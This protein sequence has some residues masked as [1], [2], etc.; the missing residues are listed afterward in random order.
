MRRTPALPFALNFIEGVNM[1]PCKRIMIIVLALLLL[2]VSGAVAQVTNNINVTATGGAS[3]I[4]VAI[5][6][7]I[8]GD[9]P[10]SWVG[11]VVERKTIGLC[12][13]EVRLGSVSPFEAGENTYQINDSNVLQDVTYYYRVYA[14]DDQGSRQYLGSPPLFPPG[15][16]H[17]DYASLGGSGMVAQGV[18]VDLGWSLGI[19]VCPGFCWET[20][21]FISEA[22]PGLVA[23]SMVQIMGTIDN[24]FEGP[25]ISSISDWMIIWDCGPVPDE[26]MS[27]GAGKA[28]FY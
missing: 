1:N 2:S 10:E 18:T 22:P 24:E 5:T 26:E 6:M 4:Q 11:W 15:Y 14:M 8:G 3:Y 19:V 25:Y 7:D 28:S 23:G 12:E 9:L 17:D 27:W 13:P 20:L 16:Y 21:S